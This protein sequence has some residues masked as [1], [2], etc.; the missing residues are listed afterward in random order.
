MTD[1]YQ[2]TVNS[3]HY[4][5]DEKWLPLIDYGTETIFIKKQTEPLILPVKGTHH[6]PFI[7]KYYNTFSKNKMEDIKTTATTLSWSG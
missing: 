5:S 4:L 2:E 3:T 6:G 7:T 1:L